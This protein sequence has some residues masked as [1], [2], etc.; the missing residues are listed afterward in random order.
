MRVQLKSRAAYSIL[1]AFAALVLAACEQ[2]PQAQAPGSPPPPA[3]SVAN[4]VEKNVVEWDE[5]T[6]RFDAVDTVEVRARISGVLNEVKFTD[7]AI[8]KK[9]DL[10]FVIDPRP[11]QR[12][13]DR[14]RAA[15]QGAKIQL[16]FAQK[17][18][19]RA[20]PLM[21]NATI[22][23]QVFDQRTQ[24]VRAAE[25]NVLSAEASV[26]SSELDV[27]FTQIRSPVTGRI[28]RKLVSEGNYI[29]GGSG[30]G[31]LLTT[32]VSIDPI[33]FYFDVSEADFLKYQRLGSMQPNARIPEIPVELALETDKGFRYK[34]NMSFI[35]NRIDPN[36]G[37]LRVRAVFNN[38]DQLLQPGLFARVRL[39][40]SGEYKAIML[41]DA[42]VAAD[43]SNR[44]VF[45]AAGDGTVSSK[46]VTLGPVIDGLRVIRS[47]VAPDDWVIVNG[48]QRA[49]TGI[50]VK[51]EKTVIGQNHKAASLQ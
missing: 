38:P 48:V 7:G 19:E 45:V 11:F 10:L 28:S 13:L 29:T 15:L 24:A 35:D 47:G 42:A 26:R 37:S 43:Q 50:K 5:Y 27:E 25:A 12:I 18:L 14:D 16:E 3:V 31:T 33:Y 22:S 9:G 21:A 2:K 36:T 39:A 17:D 30:S 44:F 6:G 41:P 51:A 20:K 8:V 23:A 40:G 49:R 4:P 46:P 34:G 1:L 32:I